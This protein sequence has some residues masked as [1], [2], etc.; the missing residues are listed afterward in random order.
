MKHN[1]HENCFACRQG[2]CLENIAPA[3][4]GLRAEIRMTRRH[5]GWLDIPHGGIGISAAL[6]LADLCWLRAR[7]ANLPYPQAMTMKFADTCRIGDLLVL[8]AQPAAE[9]PAV[10]FRLFR[11]GRGKNYL[12]GEIGPAAAEAPAVDLELPPISVLADRALLEPL[13]IY[14]NCFI[15]GCRRQAPGMGRRFFI[16]RLPAGDCILARF[17]FREED[18][19]PAAFFQQ[20]KGLLHPGV[21]GAVLDEICGWAGFLAGELFGVTV[22]LTLNFRRP[23]RAG[24]RL[25]FAAPKAAV[26]GQGRRRLYQSRGY[27]L[28]VDERE[29]YELVASAAGQWLSLPELRQQFYATRVEED[30]GAVKF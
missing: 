30:L 25:L 26:R 8:E 6:D 24:E 3:D 21:I 7:G 11:P 10:D 28:A 16:A 13:S 23:V 9:R 2:F 18:R 19:E 17:G 5:E 29:N 22:R 27:A 15:C 14:H 1:G 20:G 4:P 12:A